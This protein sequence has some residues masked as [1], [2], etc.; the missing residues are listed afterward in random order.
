MHKKKN[1]RNE[2]TE[3]VVS[4]VTGLE[5]YLNKMRSKF[6]KNGAH[7]EVFGVLDINSST[8]KRSLLDLRRKGRRGSR[9][10]WRGTLSSGWRV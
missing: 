4:L 7:L 10:L 3:S 5:Q 6:F 1:H 8:V 2:I 9:R